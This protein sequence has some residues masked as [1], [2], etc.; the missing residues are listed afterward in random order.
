MLPADIRLLLSLTHPNRCMLE[1]KCSVS[2]L[3]A[4][5]MPRAG[6]AIYDGDG[7]API[8]RLRLLVQNN[9]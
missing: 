6:R 2:V 1:K 5:A 9:N 3:A 7:S 4:C 8:A